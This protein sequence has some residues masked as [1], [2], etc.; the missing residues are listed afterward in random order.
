MKNIKKWKVKTRKTCAICHSPITVKRFRTYCSEKC[1]NK[2][3]YIKY[4]E[5]QKKWQ[6]AKYDRIASVPS[7]NKCQCLICGKWY[8]QV[9]SHIVLRHKMTAREYREEMDLDVKRGIT[10]IW[11]RK[12]K[13][14]QAI[15]N[16][17]FYNLMAGQKYWFKRGQKGL[18]KYKRSEMTM[19]RLKNNSF[20]NKKRKEGD[21]NER[22]YAGI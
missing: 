2:R 17:T 19:Q 6:L 10:P 7:P 18:G 4:K 22:I 21:K 13:G 11:Y 15:E 3:N 8:V 9:G 14:D 12:L 5:C 16:G 1:R 20:K